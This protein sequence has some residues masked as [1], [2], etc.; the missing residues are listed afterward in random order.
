PVALDRGEGDARE[1]PDLAGRD[2]DGWVKRAFMINSLADA[3][4]A[5]YMVRGLRL[6]LSDRKELNRAFALRGL[7][8]CDPDLL[9]AVGSQGLFDAL[10]DAMDSREEFV[11]R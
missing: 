8:R 3:T 1:F 9:L 7:L 2:E 4:P 11:A 10:V 6:A 5:P